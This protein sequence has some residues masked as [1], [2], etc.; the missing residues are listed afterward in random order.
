MTWTPDEARALAR[1]ILEQSKADEC[2]VSLTSTRSSHTRFAANDVTTSGTLRDASVTITSKG[3]GRAGAVTL[4]EIEPE[5]LRDAVA[6]SHELMSVAPV[7]PEFVE[8][9]GP[10]TYEEIQ[11]FH[12]ETAAAGADRRRDGVRAA[13]ETARTKGLEASGFYET[14]ASWSAIANTRG[15]FGFHR[16]TT[17]S[18]SNT[19]RTKDGTGSGW[20]GFQSPRIGDIRP[21][22]LAAVAARKAS[23]SAS[24]TDLEPGRYTVIL[25]PRAVADLLGNLGFAL[26]GRAAD[27]GRGY[28]AKPEGGT[29]VGE[30]LFSEAVTLLSDPFDPRMPGRPWA[31]GGGGGGGGGFGGGGGGT[32]LGLPSRKVTWIE[33]G[34]VKNLSIDRYWAARTKKE[35]IPFGSSL[36]LQGGKGS[37]EDLIAGT[38]RGLL[39][40]RFWYIR[41]V[42]PQTLQLTGLT[43]DGV[44][45]VEKGKV[46]RPVNNFRFNESPA[47]MLAK[48]E[49]MSEAVSTGTM[50][51]PGIRALDFNFSSKSDAV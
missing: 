23:A 43:R 7:D 24:P 41:V 32:F 20:A 12:E 17:A 15:L 8:G 5:A 44:W 42:N 2:E 45:L 3:G 4:N 1:S 49:A 11:A 48:V 16:A 21:D 19:L 30:K 25:E 34:V 10:Q 35:P 51:V 13:L 46:V 37:L 29:R 40:T 28:F 26:S 36:V 22:E 9:L 6:R 39:V 50:V 27:E 38:D 14:E 31:G 18:C 47:A 33:K